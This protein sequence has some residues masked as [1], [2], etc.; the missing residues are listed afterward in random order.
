M[1]SHASETKSGVVTAKKSG[2]FYFDAGYALF[3]KR[4]SRPL[5]SLHIHAQRGVKETGEDEIRGVTNG[6]D[7]VL[8]NARF[9]GAND[10]VGAWA[11]K[12]KGHAA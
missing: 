5:P 6:D 9:I 2:N 8:A 1:A 7:A 4:P 11:T 3:A 10:G 12:D